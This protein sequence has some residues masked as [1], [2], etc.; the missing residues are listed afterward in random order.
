MATSASALEYWWAHYRSRTR[1]IEHPADRVIAGVQGADRLGWAFLAGYD[2]AIKQLAPH[3]DANERVSLCATETNGAHPR[4]I[5]TTAR[6]TPGGWR[7]DGEKIWSTLSNRAD[8]MLVLVSTGR[9]ADRN[10]LRIAQVKA[11]DV[12][13][14]LMPETPFCPEI[15]H[16]KIRFDGVHVPELLPGDGWTDWVRPFRTIEDQFIS[17]AVA[18][19]IW[20]LGANTST[21]VRTIRALIDGDRDDP[22]THLAVAEAFDA[23]RSHIMQI[24][25]DAVDPDERARFDRDIPLLN[26]AQRARKMRLRRARERLGSPSPS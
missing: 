2:G 25:W 5:E 12:E 1:E 10:Q 11:T 7:I 24:D 6:H 15:R 23:L 21:L 19:Y 17:L 16:C 20:R 3:L 26:V 8:S 4:S 13:P 14:E 18:T 22:R 9:T